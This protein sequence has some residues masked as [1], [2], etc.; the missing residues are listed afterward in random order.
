MNFPDF[1]AHERAFQLMLQVSGR[2]GR[3]DKQGVVILQ[4]GQPEHPLINMVQRFAYKEMFSL[5]L[6]ER[7]MFHYPP[8]HRLI[9]LVL[10][11]KNESILQ[12]L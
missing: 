12:D 4:T 7:S 5:Q 6:S 1:R 2:A 10:R 8:Y 11:C 3:R 9:I